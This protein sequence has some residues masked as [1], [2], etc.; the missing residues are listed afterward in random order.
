MWFIALMLVIIALEL[1]F[2]LFGLADVSNRVDEIH[3]EVYS[4]AI[5]REMDL[6][7]SGLASRVRDDLPKGLPHDWSPRDRALW[8]QGSRE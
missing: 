4:A 6:A 8:E 7:S 5:R 3:T 1:A 2:L